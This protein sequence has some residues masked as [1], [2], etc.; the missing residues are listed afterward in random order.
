MFLDVPITRTLIALRRVRSLRDPSTNS[1]SKFSSLLE[2]VNWETNSSNEISLRFMNGGN[3]TGF[4]HGGLSGMKSSL[5]HERT[6]KRVHD[7]ELQSHLDLT[8]AKLI[9]CG[10]NGGEGNI[11]DSVGREG[12]CGLENVGLDQ[13]ESCRNKSLDE[14]QRVDNHGSKGLDLVCSTPLSNNLEDV[15]SINEHV[16]GSPLVE[17][18]GQSKP[19]YTSQQKERTKSSWMVGD[20][21]S[22]VGSPCL[23]GSDFPS[24]HS[25][26]MYANEE[27][28]FA[29]QD[30]SGCGISCCWTRTPRFRQSN[31]YDD[32]E[33]SP[34]LSCDVA[35]TT[36][37]GQSCWKPIMNETPRSLSQK[38]RPKTFYELVGQNIVAK[39]LLGAISSGRITPLYLFHGPRGTGKTS[40]SRIFAAALNCMSLEEYKPC[41]LCRECVLFSSGRSRDVHE[42]DTVRINRA[43]RIRSL[44]KNASIPP[45]S[46]RFK[47]FIIDECH[48]LDG[49]TWATVLNSLDSISRNVVFVMI[50]P[51]L[52]K[53]PRTAVARSQRYH[54]PKIKDND[55]ANRLGSIC[56][57]EGIEF[58]QVALEFIAAKSNGSLRDAEM[59]LD[60]LSLLG[61]RIT[62][63]LAYELIGVVSDDE[64]LD[65]LD[66]A[67]S[68]DTSNTVIKAREL[69]RSRID[70]MQLVSQLAN[71]IMDILAGKCNEDSSER[72]RDALKILS[73]TEKQL[74][75]SKSQST[76]LT[77]ALLQLSSLESSSVDAND[78]KSSLRSA[79][80][81]DGEFCST[82]STGESLKHPVPCSCEDIKSD[83]LQ[84]QANCKETLESIWKGALELLQSN[85]LKNF[86]WKQGKLSSLCLAVA[87]LEFHQSDYAAKAERSWKLIA[88]SL[89]SIL[90]CNVE[91]RINLVLSAPVSK[92]A[93]LRKLSFN[94]FSCS[95]RMQ[96]KSQSPLARGSDSDYSDHVSEKPMIRDQTTLTCSSDFG[97]QLPRNS[98]HSSH[99][100]E[101]V[102]ALRNND[103]NVLSIG[104]TS[105]HRS[106]PDDALKAH[107]GYGVESLNEGRSSLGHE[108]FCSQEDEG[109]SNC[110][111]R[112]LRLQKKLRSPG[113]SQGMCMVSAQGDPLKTSNPT[114]ITADD[115]C[116]FSSNSY[117]NNHGIK[118][119]LREDS[120]GLCW[121]TPL[122]KVRPA[123]HLTH[124]RRRSP[125]VEWVLPCGAANVALR[126]VT[127]ANGDGDREHKRDSSVPQAPTNHQKRTGAPVAHRI[128]IFPASYYRF[129]LSM[130]PHYSQLLLLPGFHQGISSDLEKSARE[131]AGAARKL[132]SLL[133]NGAK[134]ENQEIIGAVADSD[135][136]G[137]IRFFVSRREDSTSVESVSSV[138]YD[139]D[140]PEKGDVCSVATFRL[141]F[142]STFRRAML[143]VRGRGVVAKLKDSRV[144]YLVENLRGGSSD[145]AQPVVLR[146]KDLEFDGDIANNADTIQVTILFNSSEKSLSPAAPSA[147]YFPVLDEAR[148]LVVDF[149]LEVLCYAAKHL[150][151]KDA[152]SK[153]VV[154]GLIDQL[155]S[156]KKA[157]LPNLLT[158]HP[159]L[160][161][162]HYNPP[163]LLHP[164]TVVYELNYGETEL[165]QGLDYLLIVPF[166]EL[167]M[168]WISLQQ[169]ITQGANQD[170]KA[171][172]CSEMYTL[173][174]PVAETIISW[175]R[176][177]Y[178]T[179]I[180]VPS[181]REIQQSLVEI[182]DKEP[183]FIG[184]R[185]WIGAIELSF[186]LDKLLGVS[187]KIIN[188]RSGAELPEKCRELAMHFENQGTPIMI[189]GGVLAYTLLGV[190][191]NEASGDCAFLILDP[192]YTGTDE[193]KKIVNGGW[194]GWK[195][196]VDSK[197]KNF[198]LHDKFYNL[199]LPQRPDMV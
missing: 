1:M 144:V 92:R 101:V 155:N 40:A 63:S 114:F 130:H 77:V 131:A 152:V 64:L 82:S 190:D 44:I 182:G 74:R 188:V 46:S 186:V 145:V 100:V 180:D 153:L 192:H 170:E 185:E 4:N 196:A 28:D 148:L 189:G 83:K 25:T 122:S 147:E 108:G 76:W 50:T 165:K 167:L 17:S 35:E 175:F 143:L 136:G 174:F 81:R 110:F 99:R 119:G 24:S 187:C 139:E 91:I 177:Q 56:V 199:L 30:D 62:M 106:L 47:V 54:F 45:I 120:V 140:R 157:I 158:Q 27:R 156:M 12:E 13:V 11:G 15:D 86:L 58:D 87:E 33:G 61:R 70:P 183:S 178:Y 162:Y 116:V 78:S 71:L 104:T 181:H 41:G 179:S 21:L 97:S 111:P 18:T 79:H 10:N 172:L 72:L 142:R 5:L 194:C 128:P 57:E 168:P 39:S 129:H 134:L 22:R 93:K 124:Q 19:R 176:L 59:M 23:S 42:V 133:S 67:L 171:L 84:M 32:A 117:S 109:E 52:D 69:M 38:F 132:R 112:S 193:H 169:R 43:G 163:G 37:H 161:P 53:L 49:E 135:S 34:L 55:I 197:G 89:Q 60:Q 103:G 195:K 48:L 126:S 146:G 66:L 29:V 166:C 118:D 65:L 75:M 164:I 123:W 26:S 107:P 85:S 20:I 7:C 2:N 94:L 36:S 9:L 68:S 198:F 105:S 113:Y 98:S 95:R 149:E 96:H 88:S 150:P 6:E 137:G 138:V 73:E 8:R 141:S 51:D 115:Y 154:S 14:M 16:V 80:D 31:A 3:E 151:L 173:A 159:Q 127:G 121:R 102:R 160:R 184:S 90:G 191:Y 125:L